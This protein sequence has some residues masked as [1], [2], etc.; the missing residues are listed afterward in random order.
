MRKVVPSENIAGMSD[1]KKPDLGFFLGIGS[2]VAAIFIPILQANGVDMNWQCSLLSYLVLTTVCV[3]SL[4]RH[5]IPHCGRTIRIVAAI[6]LAVA[7]IALGTYAT[8]KQYK[9]DH[10]SSVQIIWQAPSPIEY[11]THLSANQLNAKAVSNG[12]E[13]EGG[14]VYNPT[15]GATPSAGTDTLSVLFT[16]KDS[17]YSPANMTVAILVKQPIDISSPKQVSITK[18]VVRVTG[19][20]L[21]HLTVGTTLQMR[22][23]LTNDKDKTVNIKGYFCGGLVDNLPDPTDGKRRLELENQIWACVMKKVEE[24]SALPNPSPPKSQVSVP[25]LLAGFVVTQELLAKI[26]GEGGVY[27]A[28][29]FQDADGK[30]KTVPYCVLIDKN[31]L[32]LT[33]NLCHSHN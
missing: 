6:M 16:P 24:G 10:L 13:V 5:A 26:N 32:G 9:R 25:D 1:S 31:R 2:L 12:E 27:V 19:F 14:F 33:P 8:V 22:V 23:L 15:F 20:M 28:G 17:M 29:E 18:Q 4:V 7:M 21:D 30:Y 3:W 11:G